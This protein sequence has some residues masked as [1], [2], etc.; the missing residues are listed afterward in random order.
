MEKSVVIKNSF[1]SN[2]NVVK[3]LY[4][5]MLYAIV[6][7]GAI[8][9]SGFSLARDTK[10]YHPLLTNQTLNETVQTFGPIVA[11]RLVF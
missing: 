7:L 10:A 1:C 11:T 6:L 5:L 3:L 8:L 4:V 2:A 9:L